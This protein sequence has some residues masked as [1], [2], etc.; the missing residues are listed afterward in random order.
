MK[1]LYVHQYFKTPQE[2]GSIRSYYL[3]KGLVDAGH[4]VT[5]I[6]T[7]NETYE[8][9]NVDG[10]QVHYLPVNYDNKLGFFRRLFAF[11]KFV[12]LA[13]PYSQESK[14]EVHRQPSLCRHHWSLPH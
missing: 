3:A 13:K 2:G 8:V 14:Y 1:I 11:W 5:M 12:R 7:H 6:T 10:I 4:Q 9:R